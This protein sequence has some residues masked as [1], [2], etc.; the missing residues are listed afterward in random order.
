MSDPAKP[1]TAPEIIHEVSLSSF[2]P[3]N[4]KLPLLQQKPKSP[5]FRQS[6]HLNDQKLKYEYPQEVQPTL[7]D[8]LSVQTR[9]KLAAS[10]IEIR[11]VG[12]RLTPAQDRLLNVINKLLYDKSE[13][14]D[15]ANANFYGGN[16]TGQLTEYGG[17]N[18]HS[19]AV[20]L[21]IR[22]AELY[23][24]YLDKSDYS[25]KEISNI[26]NI[27]FEL[28]EKKFLL[29][30]DRVRQVKIGQRIENRTDRIEEFQSLIKIL[31]YMEDLTDQEIA[32]LD[33]GSGEPIRERKGEVLI[34]LN[35]IIT[36]QINAKYVEYPIDINRRTTIACGG[37]QFV[38]E[39]TNTLRDY[40]LREISAKRF[41]TE[42]NAERLPYLLK[43]ENYIKT[44]RK[45]LI[46]KRIN[47]AIHANKALGL[48]LDCELI[49]SKEGKKKYLFTLNPQ[50]E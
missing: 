42:I 43:L 24:E 9:E 44:H 33:N 7:F 40:M 29:L 37:Q 5:K 19:K 46:E 14:G 32:A 31:H 20:F 35:P 41:K 22:P 39:S 38:T 25:G 30:Y 1:K 27:L 6:G 21:R 28:S 23:K 12:I 48:I 47:D 3:T 45:K 4:R 10:S 13:H 11:A 34:A 26:K 18:Q 16:E 2:A 15:P 17:A 8:A 49:A 50:F 36:D